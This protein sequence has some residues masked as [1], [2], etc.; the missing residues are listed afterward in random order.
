P[1]REFVC[2]LV[3]VPILKNA[4]EDF[5]GQIGGLGFVLEQ[6]QEVMK[7]SFSMALHQIVEGRVVPRRQARH[8]VPV[9]FIRI[10]PQ[11]DDFTSAASGYGCRAEWCVAA[12]RLDSGCLARRAWCG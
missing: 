7:Q 6:A 12:P 8:V 2:C 11:L 9:L 3:S 4:N 10:H 5:L 1:G